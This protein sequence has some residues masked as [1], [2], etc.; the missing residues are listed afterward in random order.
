VI[1]LE[2]GFSVYRL[3]STEGMFAGVRDIYQTTGPGWHVVSCRGV[4]RVGAPFG[5]RSTL[6]PSPL[7]HLPSQPNPLD[8]TGSPMRFT[9]P[10]AD[11]LASDRQG[12]ITQSDGIY[13]VSALN[14]IDEVGRCK[15]VDGP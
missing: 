5:H 12:Y 15:M 9:L 11:V 8:A 10:S 7:I 3:P 6:P 2:S 1:Q 4:E 14:R 13:L